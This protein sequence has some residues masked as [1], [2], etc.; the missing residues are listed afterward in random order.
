MSA[1]LEPEDAEEHRAVEAARRA[2]ADPIPG[3]Q[4]TEKLAER[5]RNANGRF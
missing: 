2:G 1:P 3:S 4:V 5:L